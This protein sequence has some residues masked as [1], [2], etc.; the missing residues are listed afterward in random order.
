MKRQI[1]NVVKKENEKTAT[2]IKNLDK[3]T[4]DRNLSLKREK[5][6]FHRTQIRLQCGKSQRKYKT[7][8]LLA[9]GCNNI[10]EAQARKQ[11]P[12]WQ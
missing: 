5:Y 3:E 12:T 6:I 9:R 4:L 8:L 10:H 11:L 1:L 7:L 2:R